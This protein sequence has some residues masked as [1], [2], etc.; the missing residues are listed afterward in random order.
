MR[1][2]GHLVRQ[3]LRS[4]LQHRGDLLIGIGATTLAQGVSLVFIWA[5]FRSGP[6]ISGWSYEA[7]VLLY[8]WAVLTDGVAACFIGGVHLLPWLIYEGRFDSFLLRPA[9][10]ILQAFGASASVEG[11]GQ[12]AFGAIVTLEA[13]RSLA[14]HAGAAEVAVCVALFVAGVVARAAITLLAVSTSF[15]FRAPHN[16]LVSSLDTISG[17]TRFPLS[18]YPSVLRALLLTVVPFAAT[19]YVPVSYLLH[20][21]HADTLAVV[22]LAAAAL[23]MVAAIRLFDAG[24]RRYE[25][26]GA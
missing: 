15:W 8:G 22:G 1:V 11:L 13:A 19:S 16:E 26:V 3:A 23:A 4:A 18:I 10:P 2:Y 5:V 17:V 21:P 14:V 9:S 20:R 12:V 6:E 24:R 25:G 7:M